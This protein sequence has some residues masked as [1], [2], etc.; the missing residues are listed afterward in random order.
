MRHLN[1][2]LWVNHHCVDSLYLYYNT[3][4]AYSLEEF[5][6]HFVEFKEKSPEATFV[7]EH[8]V[9]FEKWSTKHL[10]SNKYDVM[11]TNIAGS[12]NPMLVDKRESTSVRHA[13][14]LK[15][16]GNKMVTAAERIAKNKIN[17]GD[18]LEYDFVK[19]P[20]AH[21]MATLGS[22]HVDEYGMS[23]YE[24]SSPLYK[25]ET[26]FLAYSESINVVLIESEWCARR[27]AKCEYSSTPCRYQAWKEEKK[28]CQ[29]CW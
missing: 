8:E 10:S 28:T 5:N 9:G 19:I 16:K 24:Y 23:I 12:L 20:C 7:L 15:S 25:V 17:E 14:V 1:E 13:Y 6:N 22:K 26:Y 29:G 4:M 27:I 3:T 11:P 21:A 2:N 18:S